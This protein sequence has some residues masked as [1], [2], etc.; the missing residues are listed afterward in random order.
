F[1]VTAGGVKLPIREATQSYARGNS[2]AA[3]AI[4]GDPQ[5]GWSID[6]GQ[7]R[8]HWAV[9]TLARPLEN[10][11]DLAIEL[12]F[13]RYY[14]AGLGRC[15]IAVTTAGRGATARDVPVEID[16]LLLIPSGQHTD[17]QRQRLLQH[18]LL[19]AP[20]LAKERAAIEQLRKQLPTEPT[21]LVFAERPANNPRPTFLHN[22]GEFLH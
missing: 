16:E 1:S 14:A 9:F 18:F 19:T 21:T 22:R 6:G 3:A 17:Q 8:A 5:T 7:G 20:E 10:A 15:R 11:R 4:D 2:R 13:E 12:L